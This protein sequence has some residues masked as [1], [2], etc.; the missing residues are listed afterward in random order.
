MARGIYY[1]WWSHRARVES[2]L[3]FVYGNGEEGSP[4]SVL[5]AVD[6]CGWNYS[7]LM[8]VGDVKGL[9]LDNIV[10]HHK[11]KVVVELGGHFG[12]SAIRIARLLDE[13]A[14][15][16]SI[17]ISPLCVAISRE[18]IRFAG[19]SNK[20]TVV[21]SSSSKAIME[22]KEKYGIEHVDLLFIDHVGKL[23]LPDLRLM[24][25]EGLIKRGSVVVADKV[26]YNFVVD[27]LAYTSNENRIY[28]S[29][30]HETYLQYSTKLRDA[31][32]VSVHN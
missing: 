25:E 14:K 8:C 9:I 27:Y 6:K 11:P 15:L 21:L 1:R 19:L 22:L 3:D 30:L 26:H 10:I 20:C 31:I 28:K 2:M 16:Y 5:K 18:L 12:Y 24:E 23:Y 29:A 17:E 13:D 32:Q 7:P 4:E